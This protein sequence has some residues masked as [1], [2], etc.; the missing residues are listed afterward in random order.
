MDNFSKDGWYHQYH[1]NGF[2]SDW[3]S[4]PLIIG[5]YENFIIS[6]LSNMHL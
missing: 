6:K 2:L 3:K 4:S 5:Y 1:L